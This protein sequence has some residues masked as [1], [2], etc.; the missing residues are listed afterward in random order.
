MKE[1]PK[2]LF[3]EIDFLFID[4][5]VTLMRHSKL[6]EVQ[7]YFWYKTIK[8]EKIHQEKICFESRSAL[9]YRTVHA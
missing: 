3:Y 1:T 5:F 2:K 7:T 4:S 8:T 6:Y 9:A